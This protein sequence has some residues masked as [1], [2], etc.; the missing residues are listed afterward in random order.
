MSIRSIAANMMT[1]LIVVG[2][3]VLGGI[4]L[5]QQ[6]FTAPGPTTEPV[7]LQVPAGSSVRDISQLLAEAGALPDSGVLGLLDGPAMFRMAARYSGKATELKFGE[8]ELPAGASLEE[9]VALLAKGGN[10][11]HRVTVPEGMSVAMAVERI[12]A[13]EKLTGEVADLPPEGSLFPDTWDFQRGDSR[14]NVIARMQKRM[15]EVLDEAWAGRADGLPLASKRELLILASIVEKETRPQE[16]GKVAS[17]FINRLRR[18]MKLQTDPTVIY[19]IT[20]GEAPLGRGLRRSELN[21]RTPYNTYVI[22]GL[23]PTPIA[24]PGRESIMAVANP[25]ETDYLFFVADGTGGHAFAT[26]LQD[27][28][29][30]VAAWRKIERERNANQ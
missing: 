16:H 13:E 3:F 9:L 30:N 15:D 8:Y 18:G 12:K 10:V 28:N 4:G 2:L 25:E 26:N 22:D 19:G 27:H 11:R 20:L 29:K 21:A 23:P 5:A 24:N 14:Q 6:Q 1:I 7:A 17:V